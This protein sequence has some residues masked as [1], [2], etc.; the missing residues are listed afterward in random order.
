MTGRLAHG[1]VLFVSASAA[2]GGNGSRHAP[3]NSLAAVQAASGTGDKIVVLA[4]PV[5]VPPLDGGIA[6]KPHQKLIGDGPPVVNTKLALTSAPRL[7][8]STE[9]NSGDAVELA[10]DTEVTNLVIINSH[11]GGIYGL[12]VTDVKIDGN[13][14]SGT[15]TS[16]TPGFFV[17]FPVDDPLLPDGW[18]AIIVDEDV[19]SA[20]LSI[21]NNYIHD[22]TCN[23]GIDIRATETA[24]IAARVDSNNITRLAQGPGQLS[25]LA[26]GMQTR[27]TAQLTVESDSNS[28]TYI[29]SAN[30]DCE[31]LFTNQTGG[32]L[33]WNIS[34]NTFA[35]GIGGPSCNGGGVLRA[36]RP[37]YDKSVHQP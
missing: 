24:E 22:G 5:S 35:H 4:S 32:S 31:G 20:S 33:T 2:S 19:G 25:L 18:V 29:G 13:N 9:A 17:Y 36:R 23:D 15:N 8:N 34:H 26:I 6:L 3:F 30:A 14:L 7:T 10:D 27:D 28:E 12:D 11:R 1:E 21:E 37:L 16:C